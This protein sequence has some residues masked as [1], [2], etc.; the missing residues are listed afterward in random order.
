LKCKVCERETA[1]NSEYC[2]LHEAAHRNLIEKYEDW[3]KALGISW[4]EYLNEIV[5]NPLTGEWAKEVA[6]RLIDEEGK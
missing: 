2:E 1:A 3:K 5:K 4:K 6:Q